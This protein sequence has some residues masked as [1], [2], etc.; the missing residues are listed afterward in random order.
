MATSNAVSRS[1]RFAVRPLGPARSER[2]LRQD[3]NDAFA[4]ALAEAPSRSVPAGVRLKATVEPEGGLLAGGLELWL[5]TVAVAG[6][7]AMALG[8]AAA[9]GKKA[10]DAVWDAFAR[11]L[12]A[13]NIVVEKSAS[14]RAPRPRSKRAPAP[15]KKKRARPR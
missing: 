9:V 14:A 10:A 4:E 2:Q 3:V 12:R 15:I 7:K 11:R 13:R 6:G 5:M 8:A 1:V